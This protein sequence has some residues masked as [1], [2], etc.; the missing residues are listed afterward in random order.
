MSLMTLMRHPR[1]KT[2][3]L[4]STDYTDLTEAETSARTPPMRS[5]NQ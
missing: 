1:D 4:L 5:K 3:F 2:L